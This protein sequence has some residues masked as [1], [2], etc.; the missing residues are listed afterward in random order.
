MNKEMDSP[1]Q[2]PEGNGFSP[3]A[4][5]GNAALWHLEVGPGRPVLDS[6]LQS[7]EMSS[8]VVLGRF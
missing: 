6:N 5:E 7:C 8:C 2:P 1:L 4:P 3:A